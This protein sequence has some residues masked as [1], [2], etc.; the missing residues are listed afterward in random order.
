VRIDPLSIGFATGAVFPSVDRWRK[1]VADDATG[2]A[3][4]RS[5]AKRSTRAVPRR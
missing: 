4:A 2:A 5:I 1:A 3:L